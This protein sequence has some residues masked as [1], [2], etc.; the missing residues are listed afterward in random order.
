MTDCVHPIKHLQAPCGCCIDCPS[1][2]MMLV[3]KPTEEHLSSHKE[4]DLGIRHTM[5]CPKIAKLYPEF[6]KISVPKLVVNEK[7]LKRFR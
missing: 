2:I 3:T 6:K 5:D 7:L 4:Y 1:K